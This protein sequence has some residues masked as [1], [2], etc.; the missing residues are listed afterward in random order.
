MMRRKISPKEKSQIL[1]ELLEGGSS[2]AK[3][4][5]SYNISRERL[6]R[7]RKKHV[8]DNH[9]GTQR[10]KAAGNNSIGSFVELSIKESDSA[11][12]KASL[13]FDD[14]SISIEGKIN[15]TKLFGIIRILEG[16][17]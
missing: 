4:A 14:F 1:M 15:S 16:T 2:V 17:C 6:Y 7:W 12:K 9:P 8:S 13:I 3:I 10:Q 5:K 11:L